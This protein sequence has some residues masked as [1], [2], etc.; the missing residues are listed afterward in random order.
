MTE[1]LKQLQKRALDAHSSSPFKGMTRTEI[2]R[3]PKAILEEKLN[4]R[5]GGSSSKTTPKVK[6]KTDRAKA[7]ELLIDFVKT[8]RS[9]PKSNLDQVFETVWARRHGGNGKDGRGDAKEVVQEANAFPLCQGTDEKL[10][11]ARTLIRLFPRHVWRLL[12]ENPA[13]KFYKGS[14]ERYRQFADKYL[15]ENPPE[16][17]LEDELEATDFLTDFAKYMI[18]INWLDKKKLDEKFIDLENPHELVDTFFDTLQRADSWKRESVVEEFS[19]HK[20]S[21]VF[22]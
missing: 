14:K 12:T 8:S 20:P 4:T 13:Q 1:T 19:S 3:L 5:Q 7:R 11:R 18:R 2:R 10:C 17:D 15:K 9:Q 22:E 21:K 16:T 6:E